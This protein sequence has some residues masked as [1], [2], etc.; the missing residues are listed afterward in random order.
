MMRHFYKAN[1][2]KTNMKQHP[3]KEIYTV[4][5]TII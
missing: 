3:M 1:N 4:T 2:L 5:I